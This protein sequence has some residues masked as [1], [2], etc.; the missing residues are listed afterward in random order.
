MNA[1]AATAIDQV[2]KL[3]PDFPSVFGKEKAVTCKWLSTFCALCQLLQRR[4]THDA[5]N[6]VGAPPLVHLHIFRRGCLVAARGM[7]D[8]RSF[9]W[10]SV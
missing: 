5:T 3:D 4:S 10:V 9:L 6:E 7:E 2:L 8:G 1:M